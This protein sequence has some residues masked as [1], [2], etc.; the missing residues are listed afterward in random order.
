[1]GS[2]TPAS[3]ATFDVTPGAPASLAFAA[4][5]A[6]AEA[7]LSLGPVSVEVRDAFGNA[8]PGAAHTVSVSLAANPGGGTLGGTVV[9]AASSSVATFPDLWVDRAAT[10]Y[11]LR[12]TSAG[13]TDAV[14]GSFTIGAGPAARLGFRV[15][16][17]T[18]R[19]A[20][21]MMPAVEV[22][23]R[24]RFGNAAGTGTVEVRVETTPNRFGGTLYS[25]SES[26]VLASGGVAVFDPL[27]MHNPGTY[28][29]AA[30]ASGL[31]QGVSR[32]FDIV[33]RFDRVSAGGVGTC[34]ATDNPGDATGADLPY[35][36]GAD[37]PHEGVWSTPQFIEGAGNSTGIAVGDFHACSFSGR[38]IFCWG[39][40]SRGQLGNGS[41]PVHAA[42][43][44]F[45][46]L[47]AEAVEIDAGSRHTCAR[48]VGGDLYCWG[49]DQYGQLGDGTPGS[50]PN[51]SPLLVTD[52]AGGP[53]TW[54]SVS[55][56]GDHTC[57]VTD[58]G[59]A[60]CWGAGAYGQLGN[61]GTSPSAVPVPVDAPA[62]GAVL[63][64]AISAGAFHTC[65]VTDGG[66][67]YCWGSNGAGTLG[68][69][70]PDTEVTVPTLVLDPPSGPVTWATVSSG[71]NHTCALTTAG[72]AYCWGVSWSGQLGLG[73]PAGY[74]TM[75]AP[76]A[77]PA[78]GPVT[79]LDVD[80]GNSHTCGITDTTVTYC[81]GSNSEG[82][83]GD[84]TSGVGNNRSIPTRVVH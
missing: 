44:T 7:G 16:P 35:C 27:I 3:S 46:E 65:G 50:G 4:D 14:S 38:F 53:V 58:A 82:Q 17:S 11:T 22:E 64:Q 76:V 55:T 15:Q 19:A 31:E 13:L 81:W 47:A 70:S 29:L 34:V 83:V 42:E 40:G 10:G 28:Q 59:A 62:G 39:A 18:T 9:G 52:P 2:A 20:L 49:D 8:V 71:G 79:W 69:G 60:Y 61:G 36:W 23:I 21:N 32:S 12:A 45:S 51:P 56:G 77:D 33:T 67:L 37:L 78:T 74:Q 5:P 41:N 68:V 24:D 1:V 57:A 26:K 63:W 25:D 80:A 75:P 6:D 54:A 72:A 66:S 48:T 30:Y 43:P 84:G 73:D